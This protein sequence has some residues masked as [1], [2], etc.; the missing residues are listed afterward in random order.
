MLIVLLGLAN[1]G[2][3]LVSLLDPPRVAALM[4]LEL[5]G[6]AAYGEF[7]A[8]YGGLVLMLG[9]AMIGAV[10]RLGRREWLSLLALL[11][12]GLVGGRLVSL[13]L[14]GMATYTIVAVLL[15]AASAGILYQAS[16][17]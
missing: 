15:E 11:F 6:T 7:R 5:G 14:D 9:A 12:A 8:V 10:T 16:R 17:S 3:G 4:K 2:F 13:A 1:V